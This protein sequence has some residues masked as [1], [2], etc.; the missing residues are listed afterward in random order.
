MAVVMIDGDAN[1]L[2][3]DGAARAAGV[4]VDQ[5]INGYLYICIFGPRLTC[6]RERAMSKKYPILLTERGRVTLQKERCRTTACDIWIVGLSVGLGPT[7]DSNQPTK[8]GIV[9]TRTHTPFETNVACW[10]PSETF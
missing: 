2:L 4:I 5:W 8:D 9:P 1:C 6:Y 10:A 3:F 7:K